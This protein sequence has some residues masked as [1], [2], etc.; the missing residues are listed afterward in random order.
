MQ[1]DW[2]LGVLADLKNFALGNGF[3][4]LAEQLEDARIVA[5]AEQASAPKRDGLGV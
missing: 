3:P 1:H 4:A 5:M 2:I